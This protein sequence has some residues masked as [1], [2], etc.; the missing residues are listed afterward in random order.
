MPYSYHIPLPFGRLKIKDEIMLRN[1]EREGQVP[2]WRIGNTFFVWNK[3]KP[4]LT[5]PGA[6]G[7]EQD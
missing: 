2:V 3:R 6:Q 5:R 4:R 7:G 1:A